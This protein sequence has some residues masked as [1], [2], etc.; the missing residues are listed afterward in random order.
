MKSSNQSKLPNQAAPVTRTAIGLIKNHQQP[1][2]VLDFRPLNNEQRLNFVWN[3]LSGANYNSP[4]RFLLTDDSS[5]CH[6]FSESSMAI[7]LASIDLI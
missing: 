2:S 4:A 1:F 3:L 5:G 6:I 7:C